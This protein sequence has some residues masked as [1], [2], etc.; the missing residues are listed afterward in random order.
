MWWKETLYVLAIS[1][2]IPQ[3]GGTDERMLRLGKEQDGVDARQSAVGVGNRLLIFKVGNGTD[4]SENDVCSY[5]L[6]KVDGQTVVTLD[7]DAWL[8]FKNFV[9]EF[10]PLV[11]REE[12]LFCF[13]YSDADDNVV[14]KGECSIYNRV[15]PNG[16]WVKTAWENCCFHKLLFRTALRQ[17]FVAWTM[18]RSSLFNMGQK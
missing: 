15:M 1:Q 12:G 4:A 8:S 7:G 6:G 2:D 5:L 11:Q 18:G 10:N 3:Y 17:C 13:V 16:E 14:D 9:D